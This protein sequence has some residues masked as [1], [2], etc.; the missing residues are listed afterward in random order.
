MKKVKSKYRMIVTGETFHFETI[1]NRF[2]WTFMYVNLR[3]YLQ[4]TYV[5]T[6]PAVCGW[7]MYILSPLWY[8][9]WYVHISIAMLGNID[10]IEIIDTEKYRFIFDIIKHYL[11]INEKFCYLIIVCCNESYNRNTI[12]VSQQNW[13]FNFNI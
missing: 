10:N 4:R 1:L 5:C 7:C 8:Y 11:I 13:K 9:I 6:D 12:I 3:C 2:G